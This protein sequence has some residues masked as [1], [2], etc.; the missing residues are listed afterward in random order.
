MLH[1]F[2][3]C[4]YC[5][6][7]TGKWLLRRVWKNCNPAPII[8]SFTL[9]QQGNAWSKKKKKKK[10]DVSETVTRRCSLKNV[11]LDLR[12]ATLLKKRFWRTCFAVNFAKF[13]RTPFAYRARRVA[14]SVECYAEANNNGIIRTGNFLSL[15][16]VIM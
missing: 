3:Q 1:N 12:P 15:P 13:L 4:F 14:A 7:W 11:P 8:C 9:N 5:W 16:K 10:A 6:I 2:S